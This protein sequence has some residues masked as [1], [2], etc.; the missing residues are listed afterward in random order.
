[1]VTD[2]AFIA[3]GLVLLFVGGEGL[4]RGSV[5]IAERMRISKLV[6]G[7]VIV[8]F[9]TST[10][11]LLV[12]LQAA[13]AGSPEIAIGNI[14]GSN[15]A[16][17]L[18]IIGAA[19]LIWPIANADPSMRREGLVMLAVSAALVPLLMTG[20]VSRVAGLAM[21]A[22][23]AGYLF[24]TYRI[25]SRRRESA[26]THEADEVADIP[27]KPAMAA[28]AVVIG[29]G[30][31][32]LGA[33]L[34]VDGATGIAREFGVSEAV[35]GLTIVAVGTSLPELAT[36]VVAALR[37][38]ADVALANIVGSNIFN[39]LAILGITA[40]ISPI[41]VASR[42]ATLDGPVM[43]AVAA[44]LVVLLFAVKQIGR[45]LAALLLVAYA[46]YIYASALPA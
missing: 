3:A 41:P 25:E 44:V 27:L 9:G 4:V 31:L 29:L 2:L 12:S 33:R 39:I 18:L 32:M 36:S 23:L 15:I 38:H 40:A 14:I 35:I 20:M 5:A 46:A 8:G 6:V 28:A 7:M 21:L 24:I 43:L 45:P 42:F 22:L 1:M 10:P 17:V 19:A 37:R 13:M 34:L 16:N 26:F 11:E 30:M